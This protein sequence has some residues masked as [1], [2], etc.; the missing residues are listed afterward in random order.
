MSC[1][2]TAVV[3]ME[4]GYMRL[5]IQYDD[6]PYKSEICKYIADLEKKL[7]IYPEVIHRRDSKT[8]W[9]CSIEFSGDE[10]ICSRTCGEFIETLIHNLEIDHCEND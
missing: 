10:Y 1:S 3:R 7:D 8:K 9:F 2:K 4:E 5:T 6:P